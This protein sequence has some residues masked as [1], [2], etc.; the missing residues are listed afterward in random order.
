M[1][2]YKETLNL[3]KTE[4]PMKANLAQREP[5]ILKKWEEHN[6]YDKM[7]EQGKCR[8]RFILHDGPPY[9]NGHP[10]MGHAVN[11]ILKDIVNKS[12]SFSGFDTP[13]VPGWDCHGLPIELNVEKKV[14]K[15]GQKISASEFRHACRQYAASQIDIQRNAFKRLG[16]L[17]DWSHAY[18]TMDFHFEANVIRAL[19]K[20]MQNGHIQKGSKPVHWCL[21]C[22]S[23]LAEAEVEYAD[24]TSDA[25]DVGFNVVDKD[26]FLARFAKEKIHINGKIFVPIWT[27]T[28]WTL[29]ANQAVALN[30]DVDYTLVEVNQENAFLVADA[31]LAEVMQRYGI[32]EYRVL[33]KSPGKA[34]EQV[35]LQHPFYQREV[36]IVLGEHVTIESGTGAVHTAPAHGQDD[37]LLGH[38]YGLPLDNPVGDDGCYTGTTELLAGLHVNK[39]NSVIVEKLKT[40]QVLLHFTKLKHSYPHCWRHKTPL[41]FRTTPQWFISM[42][43]K[44]LRADA[45]AAIK[46]VNWIPE[47]GQ[48][49]I[50]S[51]IQNRPDWCISRQRTWGVPIALFLHKETGEPHPR[52]VE[53]ME[54]VAERIEQMGVDAWYEL[55]PKE[56]LGNEAEDYV[57]CVDILD[58]WFDSGVTHDCVLQ[59]NPALGFPAD[60][61]LEGSD[62]YRGWFQSSL[63]TSIAVNQQAPYKAV[64]THGYVLDIAGQKMSKSLGNGVPPEKV[65]Q[66]LGADV[67]RLWV[68]SID[69]RSEIHVSDEIIARTS[70]TYR[71]LRNTAR[72]LLANL[73]GFFPEKH[74]VPADHMLALD[75]WAIEKTRLLQEDIVKAYDAY[76][77]HLIYQKIHYFCVVELGSFYLDIIKDRQYTTQTDS[78]ARRSAQTAMFHIIEALTRWL[79]PILSF[80]AEEIW[81]YIPGN[82]NDMVFLN[83]WYENLPTVGSNRQMNQAYWDRLRLVRDAVNKEMEVQRG[84]GKLGAP[85]EAEV[86]LY[87]NAELKTQ[88]DL[89]QNE[90]RF[91][92]ITSHAEVQLAGATLPEEAVQTELTGLAVAV[93][94]SKHPKCERC[95]HRRADVGKHSGHPTICHRCVENV[96]GQG[97]VRLYA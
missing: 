54:K 64:L 23:A 30:A 17:A 70:E 43:K 26:N 42:D 78:L 45:L 59:H 44:Q 60:L 39:A 15:A 34:L 19:S 53:L 22:G 71:R 37:F 12:K 91:V 5:L 13:F 38:R 9:A 29:P 28:P 36:P 16:L 96:E 47:W 57:K 1:T 46:Q 80:T 66:S 2:D 63:L 82:R 48:V 81:Q 68:A 33:G 40:E 85:L 84:A 41:I 97:E 72:F 89:L 21:D 4:F 32:T 49:R 67:L 52:S 8:P 50:H 20:I 7:R 94:T 55:N 76:Q 3:P 86:I 6:L 65:I 35:R 31:L 79:A 14:G 27:T 10:H 75:V 58:V 87:C 92:L 25:I 73:V 62:Q 69:F 56:V 77:F 24:K 83:T 93:H 18:Y 74:L 61:Y 11:R 51:M 88:L 95:W 90:L